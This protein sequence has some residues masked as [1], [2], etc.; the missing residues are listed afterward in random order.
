MA[1]S[2]EPKQRPTSLCPQFFCIQC[3]VTIRISGLEAPLDKRKI[4]I[5][6]Q[7]L[8]V[9]GICSFQFLRRKTSSQL[10][11]IEGS[12]VIAVKTIKYSGCRFFGLCKINRTVVISIKSVE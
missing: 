10:A 4:F 12:I 2:Q 9:I 1:S 7:R 11:P 5:L 3:P 8:V 6:C